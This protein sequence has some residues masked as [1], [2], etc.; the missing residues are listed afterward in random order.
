MCLLTLFQKVQELFISMN[1]TLT[2]C[3][4][5]KAKLINTL[6]RHFCNELFLSV[7]TWRI[8]RLSLYQIRNFCQGILFLASSLVCECVCVW[9]S[10]V[11]CH[12]ISMNG[13]GIPKAT[14]NSTHAKSAEKAKRLLYRSKE[15][16][17]RQQRPQ[18]SRLGSKNNDGSVYT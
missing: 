14:L 4:L 8:N 16:F 5:S 2:S 10:G 17:Q 6:I 1:F 15:E 13:R 9:I 12:D 11:P 18:S 3:A 7:L